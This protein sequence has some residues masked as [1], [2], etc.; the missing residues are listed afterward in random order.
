[1]KLHYTLTN[2]YDLEYTLALALEIK[3]EMGIIPDWIETNEGERIS[4]SRNDLKKLEKGEISDVD[5]IRKHR[6][7][8]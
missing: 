8:Q 3:A 1:M 4:F 5:Y 6:I 2:I 7:I